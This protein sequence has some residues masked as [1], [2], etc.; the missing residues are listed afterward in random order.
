MRPSSIIVGATP[1]NG[2]L[3][4]STGGTL[5]ATS[6]T[7]AG[8]ASALNDNGDPT[9][10]FALLSG[11]TIDGGSCTSALFPQYDQRIY[12]NY[13]TGSR[14][15]GAGCDVGAYETDAQ[16]LLADRVFVDDYE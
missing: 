14:A 7:N 15:V 13:S 5:Q 2:S 16:D 10:T 1:I 4:S 8:L 3:H 9:R 6:T 11:P 12:F